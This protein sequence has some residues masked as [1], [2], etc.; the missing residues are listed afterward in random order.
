HGHDGSEPRLMPP[1]ASRCASEQWRLALPV[2]SLLAGGM[3]HGLSIRRNAAAH[4]G[5]SAQ[6]LWMCLPRLAQ[7]VNQKEVL[8]NTA[9]WGC[10][11]VHMSGANRCLFRWCDVR[12]RM[13][14][15]GVAGDMYVVAGEA[16]RRLKLGGPFEAPANKKEHVGGRAGSYQNG[17]P[18]KPDVAGDGTSATHFKSVNKLTFPNDCCWPAE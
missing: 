3:P 7:G 11:V 17:R 14:A 10:A 12:K 2:V 4:N 6:S 15:I 8:T 16:C 5:E 1:V 13:G 18:G 9:W